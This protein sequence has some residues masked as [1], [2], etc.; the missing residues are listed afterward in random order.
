MHSQVALKV[1]LAVKL[2][3]IKSNTMFWKDFSTLEKINEINIDLKENEKV[4][5]D[6]NFDMVCV[7]DEYFPK[8]LENIKNSEKPFLF[9]YK[10][11]LSLLN[12]AN[13]NVAVV[14]VLTPDE[15][16]IRREEKIVKELVK[17]NI[18]VVSGLAKGCDSIAH[19]ICLKNSGKTV[20]FLPTTLSN[21]YPS[22]NKTLAKN[23]VKN[24]G[25]IIS[26]YVKEPENKYAQIKRLIDRDRLQA[27]FSK[28]VV[29]IASFRQGEGDSGSRHAL[30]KA[31]EY[32]K[33]RFVMYNEKT[34]KDEA[35]FGLNEDLLK[36][37][38][39]ILTEKSLRVL[40][41]Q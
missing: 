15:N 9:I 25:L 24:G 21:I 36:D 12:I 3:I 16:I 32:N 8:V 30:Q 28:A 39:K 10:G 14:G 2:G 23:I 34:D 11:D 4:L 20:A 6:I 35:L 33:E 1:Y 31:K 29:L 18:T 17:N 22:Q 13:K 19:E 41:K 38:V 5:E 37:G 40:T 26:E 7:F 27:M